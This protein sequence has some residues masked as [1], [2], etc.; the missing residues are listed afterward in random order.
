MDEIKEDMPTKFKFENLKEK[1]HLRDIG[2]Y[3]RIT[4]KRILKKWVIRAWIGFN[5]I[6]IN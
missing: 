3:V 1:G 2:L 5:W 6:R 4:L